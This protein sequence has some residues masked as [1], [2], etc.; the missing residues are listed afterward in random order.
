MKIGIIGTGRMGKTLGRLWADVGHQIAFGSRDAAR[1]KSTADEI[2]QGAT[3]STIR[4]VVTFGDVILLAFPW[5]AFTDIEREVGDLIDGKIV[6][7]C[8]NPFRS[9]GSLALGHKWSAGEEIAKVWHKARVVK[10]FNHT[11]TTVLEEA[12]KAK[13]SPT[14]FY[15]GNDFGAK[16]I[17]AQLAEA[18]N[19]DPV[20]AG[21]IKNS[22][23]LEPLAALWMQLAFTTHHGTQMAF[24]LT[25]VS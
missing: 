16:E 18:I 10:A 23:L 8:I 6:I 4:S 13:T 21:P 25:H 12:T 14:L 1:G 19:L 17:V 22:R 3:G 11:Y 24:H 2:G 20:D 5:Y 9:T 7:D 15:C